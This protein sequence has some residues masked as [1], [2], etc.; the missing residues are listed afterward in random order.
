MDGATTGRALAATYAD[1]PPPPPP[2]PRRT[3]PIR[4]PTPVADQAGCIPEECYSIGNA[5]APA[6]DTLIP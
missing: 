6:G 5:D 4:T 1:P 2:P 3:P